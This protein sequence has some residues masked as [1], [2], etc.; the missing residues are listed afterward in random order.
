MEERQNRD[1]PEV[2]TPAPEPTP[3]PMPEREMPAETGVGYLIVRVT[4]A[5]G[6]I[7]LEG[8]RVDIRT[9][10]DEKGSDPTSRGDIV[11]SLITGR[12]GSTVRVPLPTPPAASSESP[13]SNHPY[14]RYSADV[15][16]DGYRRQSYLG[17]PI[18]D[19]ITSLQS[20]VLIPLPED[21]SGGTIPEDTQYF[22][23][24]GYP[25]L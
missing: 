5:R 11:A 8:A 24:T 23:E 21:G 15:F 3:T 12:D 9:Y 19:G 20:A 14:A 10:E 6:A 18:F 25:E 13:G 16:L 17:I 2:P 4:T 1:T 7:P 22:P